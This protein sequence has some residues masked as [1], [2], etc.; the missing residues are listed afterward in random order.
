MCV[1]CLHLQTLSLSSRP[2][3]AFFLPVDR[4]FC[5]TLSPTCIPNDAIYLNSYISLQTSLDIALGFQLLLNCHNVH[6]QPVT[7]NS[8]AD[9][10]VARFG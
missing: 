8:I 5:S 3:Q 9:I 10:S 6:V 1:G 7:C 4:N 2:G